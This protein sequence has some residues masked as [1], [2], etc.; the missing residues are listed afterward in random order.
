MVAIVVAAPL[1]NLAAFLVLI[2]YSS[3]QWALVTFGIW[4]VVLICQHF[5]SLMA[6]V[7][8]GKESFQNDE[9]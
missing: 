5:S 3:W 4:I 9:R 1:I 8:K 7:F 6:K 2:F